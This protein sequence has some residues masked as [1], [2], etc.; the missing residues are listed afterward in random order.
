[1]KQ[2]TNKDPAWEF[3]IRIKNEQRQ[4]KKKEPQ[5]VTL[6]SDKNARRSSGSFVSY[7][8]DRRHNQLLFEG[9]EKRVAFNQLGRGYYIVPSF[10]CRTR[11]QFLFA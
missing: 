10:R 9:V 1:M 5:W 4:R 6:K 8:P 11:L 2:A 3:V 7:G